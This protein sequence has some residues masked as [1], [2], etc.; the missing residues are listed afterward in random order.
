MSTVKGPAPQK[1]DG[2]GL[3]VAIVHARWNSS[4]IEPLVK[5]TVDTLRASGVAEANIVIQSVPG[6]WELPIAVQRS[7]ILFLSPQALSHSRIFNLAR[8][9]ILRSLQSLALHLPSQDSRA[10]S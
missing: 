6:A 2:T 7:V 8:S 10:E 4:I 3:R 1:H 5:G 9:P